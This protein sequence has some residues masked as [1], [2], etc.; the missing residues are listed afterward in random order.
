MVYGWYIKS[1]DRARWDAIFGSGTPLAEQKIRDALLGWEE[2]YYDGTDELGPGWA[3]KK[4]LASHKGREATV[5]ATHL[6]RNGFTY[7]GLDARQCARLD[8]LGCEVCVSEVLGGDLDVRLHSPR[9][10]VGSQIGELLDRLSYNTSELLR[11]LEL[12]QRRL[13]EPEEAQ[14]VRRWLRSLAWLLWGRRPGIKAQPND[15]GRGSTEAQPPHRGPRYLPLLVSGRRFGTEAQPNDHRHGLYAIFSPSEV[16]ELR[17]EV[18]AAIDAPISW[19]EPKWEPEAIEECF[20][21]PL[22][23]VIQSGRWLHMRFS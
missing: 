3:R 14:E 12:L 15:M 18:V 21:A 23:E 10:L 22:T 17:N 8:N 11:R 2:G 6:A 4:I 13:E 20:L 9:S 1:F 7:D 5:L 16:V 19:R